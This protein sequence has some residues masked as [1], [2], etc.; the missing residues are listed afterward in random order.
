MSTWEPLTERARRII[1]LASDQAH[2][3]RANYIGT[4]HLLLGIIAD[5]GSEAAKVLAR[6]R[7]LL[8]R[9][10]TEVQILYGQRPPEE[11]D[12]VAAMVTR[13]AERVVERA[14]LCAVKRAESHIDAEHLLLGII[15]EVGGLGLRALHRVADPRKIADE[16]I[17]AMGAGNRARPD[18]A[19]FDALKRFDPDGAIRGDVER[20]YGSPSFDEVANILLSV[21]ERRGMLREPGEPTAAELRERL[22]ALPRVDVP[23]QPAASVAARPRVFAAVLWRDVLGALEPPKPEPPLKP[24]DWIVVGNC[25]TVLAPDEA[26]PDD[27][28]IP[29]FGNLLRVVAGGTPVR[30]ATAQEIARVRGDA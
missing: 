18:A 5:A 8:E 16:V 29:G 12:D 3:L 10:R 28:M 25:T 27:P 19:A 15:D 6:H 20:A 26:Q 30:R 4:E 14:R 1:A 7:V 22:C 23:V 9:A 17:E 24:G 2:L 21:L 13:H 11:V